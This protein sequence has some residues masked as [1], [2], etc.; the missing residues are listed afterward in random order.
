MMHAPWQNQY[1]NYNS[2]KQFVKRIG[3]IEAES[4]DAQNFLRRQSSLSDA[5]EALWL[6]IQ[7]QLGKVNAFMTEQIA[8]VSAELD[9][10]SAEIDQVSIALQEAP[11]AREEAIYQPSPRF[12]DDEMGT[13]HAPLME[14]ASQQL[15]IARGR[16]RDLLCGEAAPCP[17]TITQVKKLQLFLLES[18]MF[19]EEDKIE[20]WVLDGMYGPKTEEAVSAW[21]ASGGDLKDLPPAKP[22]SAD[23]MANTCASRLA[24]RTAD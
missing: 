7:Q 6:A 21:L 13:E 10:A 9:A 20:E 3:L 17:R 14:P 12:R 15:P 19:R 24:F 23:M 18:K 5:E 4:S 2:L 16:S 8:K 11:L 22:E 1:L